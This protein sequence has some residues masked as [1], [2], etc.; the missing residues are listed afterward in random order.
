MKKVPKLPPGFTIREDQEQN[1]WFVYFDNEIFDG[2]ENI[3][4]YNEAVTSAWNVFY[5]YYC[6][7][8]WREFLKACGAP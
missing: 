6:N 5:S 8:E 4:S 1:E 3:A 7:N 2:L